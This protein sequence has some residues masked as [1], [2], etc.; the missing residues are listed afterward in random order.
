ML[1][2]AIPDESR[3]IECPHGVRLLCRPLT[4]AMNH[5]AMTR[6]ARMVRLRFPEGAEPDADML[7]GAT[8]AEIYAALAE[9]LVEGW[10]GVGNA[11]GTGPAPVTPE[12]VRMLMQIP[13]VAQAFNEG[14]SAPLAAVEAEGN[15]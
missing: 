3:W 8:I 7:R 10:E 4:T 15:A 5:A 1:R 11:D 6:A 13:E 9:L 12:N 14:V 2:L